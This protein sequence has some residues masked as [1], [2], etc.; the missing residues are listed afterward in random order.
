MP[1]NTV[2]MFQSFIANKVKTKWPWHV[3][4]FCTNHSRDNAFMFVVQMFHVALSAKIKI[5][6]YPV[7]M[8]MQ[9][10]IVLVIG[11]GFGLMRT[12]SDLIYNS[13]TF[14]IDIVLLFLI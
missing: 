8:T 14:L 1:E 9:T 13:I 12:E 7:P 6:F 3:L 11:I 4:L 2:H 10:L 5:P